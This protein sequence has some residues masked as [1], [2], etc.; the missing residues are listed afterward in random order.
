[1][2]LTIIYPAVGHRLGENYVG[3]WQLEPLAPAIIA[4]LTPQEIE[5]EFYD[6]RT[7]KIPYDRPTDLVVITAIQTTS[8]RRAYQIA[9][10]YRQRQIPV[11]MGGFHVTLMPEEASD[12]AEAI[13]IGEAEGLWSNVIED[14]QNGCLRRVYKRNSRPKLG[15][16]QVDRSI[17]KGKPY[18]PLAFVE[19]GRGCHFKCDFCSIQTAFGNSQSRRPHGEALAELKKIKK[20]LIVFCDD[21]ITSNLERA[22]AFFKELIPLK[23]RWVSQCSINAAHDEE[24]LE[25]LK[26]SGCQGL[27]IGFESIHPDNLKR[28]EKGFNL[29][30]GGYEVAVKNLHRH[31]IR[32]YGMFLVGY[33]EDSAETIQAAMDFATKH[34]FY[35]IA[36]NHLTPFP[37]TALYDRMKAE[38]R[39]LFDRWWLDPNYRYGSIPFEPKKTPREELEQLAHAARVK[40]FSLPSILKRM[41]F[42]VNC[43]DGLM[44]LSFFAL[45]IFS[46]P[47][48]R[49]RRNYPL[50][51][52]AY[53]G[54]LIKA[55]HSQPFGLDPIE[56][57][58]WTTACDRAS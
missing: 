15:G 11:V 34:K 17:F 23:I 12:Y 1:M 33:D 40:F 48:I 2:R 38:G 20:P 35:A 32:I 8:A 14:F 31:G 29:M 28:M 7:E 36:F 53:N 41:N 24:F 50:G 49:R 22:K 27:L 3:T 46:H 47:G 39:L 18:L 56:A 4:G 55:V 10:L 54:E 57:L 25:L 52:E 51:D 30:N 21:N 6:D 9:S 43:T 42:G 45:N 5:I 58:E 37:G 19:V 44:T 26:A 13:V 16:F